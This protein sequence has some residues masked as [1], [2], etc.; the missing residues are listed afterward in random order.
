M[1]QL[2]HRRQRRR[3]LNLQIVPLCALVLT[4]TVQQALCT[5]SLRNALCLT[6]Q[7]QSMRANSMISILRR[8]IFI[9][10]I[11]NRSLSCCPNQLPCFPGSLRITQTFNHFEAMLISFEN[12]QIFLINQQFQ[13]TKL[14]QEWKGRVEYQLEKDSAAHDSFS[15]LQ[16][17]P[18]QYI[19]FVG[20]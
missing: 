10:K 20:P 5:Q 6:T 7:P 13:G 15:L 11:G 17:I 9:F 19:C 1:S 16:R 12:S 2:P 8:S 3:D 14:F 4:F 18:V